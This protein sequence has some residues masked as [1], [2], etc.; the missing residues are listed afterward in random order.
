NVNESDGQN[1]ESNEPVTDPLIS[2]NR[3]CPD[4]SMHVR[5]EDEDL[6][7]IDLDYVEEE[8]L[9]MNKEKNIDEEVSTDSKKKGRSKR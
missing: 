7:H 6:E 5:V 1:V 9:A 8:Y 3:P 2:D 4:T